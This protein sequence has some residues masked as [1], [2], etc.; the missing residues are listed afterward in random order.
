[1]FCKAGTNLVE[2]ILRI[3]ILKVN[4]LFIFFICSYYFIDFFLFLWFWC[5]CG[6]FFVLSLG[7][8]FFI[9]LKLLHHVS[10]QTL[11]L[12]IR[13]L[14]L[15]GCF[16]FLLYLFQSFLFLFDNGFLFFLLLFCLLLV[17]FVDFLLSFNLLFCLFHLLFY[18]HIV[19]RICRLIFLG[20]ILTF[21]LCFFII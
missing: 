7:W 5:L 14:L 1:M 15:S 16:L 12:I 9:L 8:I 17:F 19:F 18:G 21:L 4:F 6:W 11:W 2:S 13:P 3:R 10:I 20:T